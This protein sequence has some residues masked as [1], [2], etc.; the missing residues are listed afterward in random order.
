MPP[1][2]VGVL[3]ETEAFGLAGL[4]VVDEAEVHWLAYAA[5]EVPDLFFRDAVGD[6][7][8]E[9]YAAAFFAGCHGWLG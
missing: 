7:A 6:V 9:D 2:F 4:F 3:E 5:E 8:Y 1:I